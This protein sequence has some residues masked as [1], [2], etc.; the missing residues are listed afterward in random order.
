MSSLIELVKAFQQSGD[1]EIAGE[2]VDR[3]SPDLHRYIHV[4]LHLPDAVDD[5]LQET[6]IAIGKSLLR[7]TGDSDQ[8][9]RAYCYAICSNKIVDALRKHGKTTAVEI[10]T[11]EIWEAVTASAVEEPISAEERDRL[12]HAI[13]LVA[14]VRPPCRD[15]LLARYVDGLS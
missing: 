2:I 15:Y 13:N 4:R 11:D 10:S 12:E 1:L 5:V 8:K 6:L 7:F 3:L 14:I 9:F